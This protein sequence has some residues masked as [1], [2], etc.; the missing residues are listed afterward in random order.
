MDCE[1]ACPFF[2]IYVTLSYC[3]PLAYLFFFDNTV[4]FFPFSFNSKSFLWA[5]QDTWETPEVLYFLVWFLSVY[6]LMMNKPDLAIYELLMLT[7]SLWIIKVNLLLKTY[8]E[9]V[10]VVL[11]IY[12]DF[13]IKAYEVLLYSLNHLWNR[14]HNPVAK[15]FC[16]SNLGSFV[17]L[18]FLFCF[19][20]AI[21][22]LW[23][24][25]KMQ[26]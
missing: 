10:E 13:I 3:F 12:E 14:R 22:F 16:F 24:A 26:A 17:V 15:L 4:L 7:F 18:S 25:G 11:A 5:P 21:N 2:F 23:K 20:S 6:N 8:H 9:N 19:P 1:L